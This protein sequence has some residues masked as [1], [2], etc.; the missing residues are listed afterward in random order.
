[1]PSSPGSSA[2]TDV[3]Y[4]PSCGQK[5]RGDLSA[6]REGGV[7]TARCAGCKAPLAVEFKAGEPVARVAEAARPATPV[8]PVASGK[9]DAD[10]GE[11]DEEDE[12]EG[13]EDGDETSG[14][15]ARAPLG[16]RPGAPRGRA[17]RPA[18][19]AGNRAPKDPDALARARARREQRRKDQGLA[20]EAPK[21]TAATPAVDEPAI[22]AELAPGTKVDRYTVEDAI[23]QGGTGTVY[24][25]FDATTN[26]YVA[27]KLIGAD[28][29]EAMQQRFLR[30]IEVQANL[31]HP[32]LMP[33]FDRG[34]YLGRPYFTMELLYRPFTLTQVVTMARN[35]SLSRYATLKDLG[36]VPTLLA[37]V[38]IPVCEGL[39]VANVENGV[40]HRDLKP[41]NVL[42]DS[43]TLRPYVIDFGICHVLER[44]SR[45]SGVALAP[46]AADAGIVG[47]P[48]FLAPE[49]AR[50]A[51]HERTDVWGLGALL[52]YCLT[53]E[54]P[55]AAASGISRAELKARV[56]ALTAARAE[57]KAGGDARKAALCDE[58]LG[59]LKDESLRTMDD[60]FRDARDG[61]Y[62]PLPSTVPGPLAA[63]V[64]K[65]MAAKTA[66]RYVNPR[67]LAADVEAHLSGRTTR[68][69][70]AEGPSAASV[71]ASVGGALRRHVVTALIALA[72]GAL[73]FLLGRSAPGAVAPSGGGGGVVAF[74]LDRLEDLD[75]RLDAL[76]RNL[77]RFT[78]EDA[79]AVHDL[80]AGE[81][82][83]R[84][85]ALEALPAGGE[86]DAALARAQ[87][88]AAR[89][90]PI[91]VRVESP[92]PVGA[93]SI[94]DTVRGG[95][96]TTVAADAIRLAPGAWRLAF[97]DAAVAVHVPVQVP[98]LVRPRGDDG[99]RE[100]APV[101]V[102]LPMAPSDVPATMVLVVSGDLGVDYRGPPWS[103][104]IAMPVSVPPFLMDRYE[105][106]NAEWAEFLASLPDDATRRAHKPTEDFVA[107]PEKPGQFMLPTGSA[108]AR[109]SELPVRGISPKDALAFCAWRS[110]KASATVRL[111]TE[112]EW[113]V[114]AGALLR[115]D[116][117]CG[118]RGVVEEA[119]FTAPVS[120]RSARDRSPYG[121][122]GLAGNAREWVTAVGAAETSPERFLSKGAGAGDPPWEAAIRRVRVGPADVKDA[123]T[124]LRCVRAVPGAR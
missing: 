52:R 72:L 29:S 18:K 11:S 28:Q 37:D 39:H 50:G 55:L 120:V 59:R 91:R 66:E 63:I 16:R 96:A 7:L 103:P 73:G 92:R 1:M 8:P 57:A 105:V 80:L 75:R 111:P 81:A 83:D 89:L 33:V 69:A 65:A 27:L 122:L 109:T 90:A 124:G 25:A 102:R 24:R 42:I 35:G 61:V 113:A 60:L 45:T 84:L 67:S 14:R 62:P 12:D 32:N 54:P 107:D 94:E 47:T 68:A 99:D 76:A 119:D 9:A 3:F 117:A 64:R 74:A 15:G 108:I 121:M 87:T 106:S 38:F 97:G 116:L 23:G 70:A 115:Y 101:T 56:E 51:V 79:A 49:Q 118:L 5:H 20:T 53:G 100:P 4:C 110:D 22:V 123:K 93:V 10:D 98:L 58:K 30:E 40:V 34:T 46:T 41:D 71:V 112:A 48:R 26:R 19:P 104:A 6:I 85:K 88:I 13:E 2:P 82:A 31:R 17:E 43:R 21:P 114:A 95:S 78:T 77:S 36:D 86:R 44:N